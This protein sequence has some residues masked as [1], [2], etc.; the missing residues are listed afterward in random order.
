M[1]LLLLAL[2]ADPRVIIETPAGEIEVVLYAERAPITVAN[3][4][5]YVTAGSYT[6][7]RVHRAVR[8][9]NQPNNKIKI[10]VIQAGPA[11]GRDDFA[12]IQLERTYTTGIKHKDGVIS[13]ARDG[14]NT[15]TADFFI[16]IGDQPELDFAGQR[17]PD[18]QGFA[19][20]GQVT[21]G[22]DVVRKIQTSPVSGQKLTPP[23]QIRRV[24]PVP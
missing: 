22:M 5:R 12:P 2:A 7:G 19:A 24:V 15:A 18:G 1:I 14:P 17:N 23:I 11:I 21:K 16:C 10:E 4:L 6:Q 20:F 13:M 3:F 9:D 8:M